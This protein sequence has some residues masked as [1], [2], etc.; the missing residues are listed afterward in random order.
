[1]LT[2]YATPESLYSAKLRILLRHKQA[3]WQE[4]AP[5]G[6]CGSAEYRELIPAGTM[7]AIVDGDLVLADSEAIAE[8]LNETIA[9]PAMLPDDAV[10]RARCRERSRFHDTRLEPEVRALFPH[11]G[12]TTE[13]A[14]IVDR[15]SIML[16]QRLFELSRLLESDSTRD[17]ANLSL[18]DCGFPISFAWID[19]FVDVMGLDLYWPQAVK[20]YRAQIEVHGAVRQE[21]DAY[22]AAMQDWL[23]SRT[24][25]R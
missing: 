19:A 4:I 10:A 8:Y 22:A 16:N 23:Q 17:P 9:E 12:K 24:V 21:L 7:P 14:E 20:D 25:T 6:G 13:V 5:E 3:R 1:M 11:V 15:Q 2:L 18:A